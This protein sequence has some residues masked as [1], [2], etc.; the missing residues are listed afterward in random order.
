MSLPAV[1]FV[2][3]Q[4]DAAAD[5]GISSISQIISGLRQHRPIIVTDRESQRVDEWRQ[6]GIETH[7]I[8]QTTSQG[9]SRSPLGAAQSFL[10][11]TRL[12][13][14]LI[15]ASGA[16]V[17]HANDPASLQLALPAVKL[18]PSAKIALNIRD[19]LDPD[20]PSPR[21]RY[22]FFFG[23]ADHVFFLSN[24]MAD[25]WAA[26]APNANSKCTIT[27][28]VVDPAKFA[29]AKPH[30]RD[31]P[32]VVLLSGLISVK[33]GQ[34][35][36][37]R[38]VSPLLAKEGIATWLSGDFDPSRNAYMAACAEAAAPLG[39]MV[40]FLGFRKD[41]PD[42][43][44]RSAV[45]AVASRH[46]GL[47]R[48]MIEAMACGRP[49]VSFDVCSAREMLEQQSGGAGIV[50]ESNDFRAMAEGIVRFC[51][52]PEFA[53]SAGSKGAASAKKLFAPE[54]VIARYERVYDLLGAR[55]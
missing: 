24:D 19:T 4:T 3:V 6:E 28:S 25:R 32:P 41:I 1:I 5:G 10:R 49:V 23:A 16:K 29:Q 22:R 21:R 53:A 11:Y 17:V 39:K 34:L 8:P 37:I 13:R 50:V 20:R 15:A 55:E 2:L 47:V 52:E 30:S 31:G 54:Q 40:R 44:A 14:R 12:L 36:F 27:Y 51:R 43:M 38:E 33:K 48:A 26:V 18:S 45:V 46:E 42:L 9:I 35:G 7:V